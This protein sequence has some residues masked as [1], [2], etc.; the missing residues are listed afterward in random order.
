MELGLIATLCVLIMIHYANSNSVYIHIPFCRQR[1]YYCNFPINIVGD[2]K[3]AQASESYSYTKLILN[4]ID[5]TMKHGGTSYL[6]ST[7]KDTIAETK[8]ICLNSVYF[9]GGTPSL[10]PLSCVESI[11]KKLDQY[12]GIDA[13]TEITFEMD[14]GTFDDVK[15]Q[16]LKSLGV[17]RLSLGIQS[18][19]DNILK[20]CGRAHTTHDVANAI[21]YLD[22][23]GFDNFS[24]DLISS[25]PYLSYELWLETL[26]KGVNTGCSHIS[27]YDLQ[28][29]DGTAFGRWYTN[30]VFPLPT[31]KISAS[32]YSAAVEYLCGQNFE[33]YEVSNYA[34]HGRRSRHNQAYWKCAQVWGFGQGAASFVNNRRISRPGK[35]EEYKAWVDN[36]QIFNDEFQIFN[37]DDKSEVDILEVV[38]LAL[39]TSDGLDLLSIE[40]MYGEQS[41]A[42]VINSIAPHVA[43]GLVLH[44][45]NNV[46][47]TDPQG[48]L[49]SN[50]IISSVFAALSP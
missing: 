24:I 37:T 39:R 14:P 45:N 28:V 5:M 19:D 36:I 3:N 21:R 30:G 10:L 48:F 12:F 31:E 9:G 18:F 44:E 33:H 7:S 17:N 11:L 6:S 46:R 4:E 34:V 38:M 15:V 35:M 27:V 2:G 13:S 26:Q 47:L 41:K 16:Q 23:V 32:M 20:K 25:L 8:A 29:E 49:L 1:C 40:K 22:K 42:L 43:N 50:D